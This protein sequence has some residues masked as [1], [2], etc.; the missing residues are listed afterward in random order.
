MVSFLFKY[1]RESKFIGEI[2]V[3]CVH[4]SVLR[5][6][7]RDPESTTGTFVNIALRLSHRQQWGAFLLFV[8]VLFLIF[9]H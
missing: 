9:L 1:D 3:T 7:V 8:G 5:Q 2:I 4:V 6:K